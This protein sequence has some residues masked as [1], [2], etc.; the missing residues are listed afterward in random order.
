M[1]CEIPKTGGKIPYLTSHL[2]HLVTPLFR[3]LVVALIFA[4]L[5]VNPDSAWALMG[6]TEST[7]GLDG[8]LS[9]TNLLIDNYDFEPFFDDR[10]TDRTS[11][12]V[13][14]LIAAGR[15]TEQ[16]HYEVHGVQSYTYST[17][18][19]ETGSSLF[20]TSGTDTRYRSLDA[21]WDWYESSKSLASLWL[22]RFNLKAALANAD[23]TVG[24][25][26][27]TFGKA[28]FWNPLDIF[29]PF[30]PR[31]FD[32]DYKAG[33]DALRMDIPLGSFT[34]IN[35]ISVAGRE[36]DYSGNYVDD[37]TLNASWYG[38][39]LLARTFTTFQGWDMALQGGKVYSGYQLGGGLVGEI[40]PVETRAEAAYF[41][42]QDS[43]PLPFPLE[44]DLVEDS[45]TG[46]L[47]FGHRFENTLTLEIEHFYNGAGDSNDLDASF[48]RFGS[49][50][51]LQMSRNLTGFLISYEF[52]PIITGQFTALY[53]W[54]DPSAQI[55]PIITWSPSNN[56]EL[57]LGASINFGDRPTR[58]SS[59][60]VK[61]RS[62]FGTFPDFYFMQF[63]LYF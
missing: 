40:G 42:A 9:T 57:I 55:Q 30:D 60:Q 39:A 52:E 3:G 47:G 21:T 5:P 37:G 49:G 19:R 7:F 51:I 4:A 46:V 29:L 15:P 53:S 62:E 18:R 59:G 50:N 31:Q 54:D 12:N 23:I 25:Q 58:D 27:I 20:G 22:D 17:S 24:R 13:L 56:T 43:E 61:I 36:L 45:F 38:S 44:G 48:V 6:D 32:R 2:S 14:R 63:K 41:W 8:R 35:L 11:Q 28:Y 34:G 10:N 16:L 33:V 26:P 1:R